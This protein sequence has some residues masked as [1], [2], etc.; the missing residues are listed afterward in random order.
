M[1]KPEG[2]SN[3]QG[4]TFSARES[5]SCSISTDSQIDGEEE[6]S[7][8]TV[9]LR[10]KRNSSR[11]ILFPKGI[12][13]PCRR[14][15]T[16]IEEEGYCL[17]AV[18]KQLASETFDFAVPKISR[19]SK[20]FLPQKEHCSRSRQLT[21]SG[22]SPSEF[23]PLEFTERLGHER[24]SSSRFYSAQSKSNEDFSQTTRVITDSSEYVEDLEDGNDHETEIS[25][26]LEKTLD[27]LREI[28]VPQKRRR[29]IA[30]RENNLDEGP[31]TVA[32]TKIRS[33]VVGKDFKFRNRNSISLDSLG[34]TSGGFEEGRPSV[35]DDYDHQDNFFETNE[36][37]SITTSFGASTTIE[38]RSGN[39][40]YEM[41]SALSDERISNQHT[42]SE[43]AEGDT[44]TVD[45]TSSVQSAEGHN[46][47]LQH[48][49]ERTTEESANSN[50]VVDDTSE[51]F[52]ELTFLVHNCEVNEPNNGSNG[53][54]PYIW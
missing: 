22:Y 4:A 9:G 49:D 39:H 38:S 25:K 46:N 15:S 54:L 32:T 27:S 7:S 33:R 37:I 12:F 29:E 8:S 43:L 16:S 51:M 11:T 41:S 24:D 53:F 50:C 26:E 52:D 40:L 44:C 10:R 3:Y 34:R 13:K 14:N 48:V 5:L 23:F 47:R 6:R 19:S 31:T 30:V 21:S 28:G 1:V 45:S 36:S 42:P 35:Y 2:D 20:T 17:D 18:T